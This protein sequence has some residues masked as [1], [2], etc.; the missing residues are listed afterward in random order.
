[1]QRVGT[2]TAEDSCFIKTHSNDVGGPVAVDPSR[3]VEKAGV[4]G[5]NDSETGKTV[6]DP[7]KGATTPDENRLFG[8]NENENQDTELDD[9]SVT[10]QDDKNDFPEGGL[11]SWSVVVG[12]FCGLFSVFGIINSTAVLLQYMQEN[13]LKDYSPSEIGW[14]F[15]LSLFLTF[16]CGAP[17]GPIFDAYGPKLL[18]FCG[19]ILLI[20]S[21]FL[22]GLCTQYWHFIMVY[23]VLNGI[24]GA[25][26]NTPC[27]ASVGHFFLVKRGNATGI[28]MTAGSIGGIIFPLMLQQLFP[29]IGFAWATRCVGFILVFLLVIANILVQSRL[30]RKKIGSFKK[31]CPDLTVFKDIPFTLVTVG[32]FFMEWGIFV[33]LTYITSYVIAHG[34]STAFGFQIL[35]IVNAGSFFGRFFAGL[36]ADMIGRIN[37]LTLTLAMC[38]VAC[39]ALWLP[40]SDST[41]MVVVFS[42]IFGCVSGSNLSLSPVCVGQMCKTEH[43]GRYF[44]TC[45][46][47]VSFGTLTGLPI[48]GQILTANGGSYD[49][50]V[51]FAALSYTVAMFCLIAARVLRVGWKITAVY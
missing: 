41:A 46:M 21:M 40:A 51:I 12:A 27:I 43:Y 45:W 8:S 47:F 10:G 19:S 17:I 15:G 38:V 34:H 5:C 23:S 31:I 4:G 20:A 24:G 30:P 18:I 16:F 22:L 26:I 42:V 37:T 14:I 7:E 49:G 39:L 1:M 13:Q 11:K 3:D 32:I 6:T 9:S 48:A 29:A 2:C 50:L 36:V 25:L 33:P 44:A 35:A 28:A